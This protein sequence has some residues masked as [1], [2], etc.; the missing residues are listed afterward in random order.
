MA[1]RGRHVRRLGGSLCWFASSLSAFHEGPARCIE[2]LGF[3]PWSNAVHYDEEAGRRGAFHERSPAGCR[4]VTASATAAA[5]HFVGTELAEVVSL[6][7]GGA[8]CVR[9]RWTAAAERELASD[10][11]ARPVRCP[12]AALAA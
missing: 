5:L 3:L 7:P 11:W 8:R 6:A 2:G 9:V 12:G 1:G 10:T 4:P